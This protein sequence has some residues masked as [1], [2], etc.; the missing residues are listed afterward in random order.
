VTVSRSGR[1][2][3]AVRQFGTPS[4]TFLVDRMIELERLGWEAWVA[5]ESVIDNGY[6]DFP[7]DERLLVGRR[8]ERL[9]ARLRAGL[10]LRA[11]PPPAWWVERAIEAVRPKVVHAHFGWNGLTALP[12]AR[13]RQVPLVVGLHGYDVTVYPRYGFSPPENLEA[14]GGGGE[15][16]YEELFDEASVIVTSRYLERRLRDLGYGQPVEVIPSGIRLDRFPFRGP[17]PDPV[18]CRLLFVGRL[19]PYKGLDVLVRALA[20]LRPA[21]DPLHLDVVGDGPVR[22]PAERLAEQLGVADL[23]RF[24]GALPQSGVRR[25]FEQSDVLVAPSRTTPAGQAEALGNAIKEALAVGLQVVASR[26]GGIPE[27]TPPEHRP[28]LISEGDHEALAARIEE[29]WGD[30]GRW[31]TRAELG[32]R[33]VQETFDWRILAPRIASVYESSV[34]PDRGR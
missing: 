25:A 3:H 24:H 10:R 12:A 9:V 1:V 27:V 2:L 21:V 5:A 34:G 20:A 19:V 4:E 33:W 28:E 26:N 15:R 31:R 8:R 13:D 18:D 7:P 11:G 32:R 22:Q 29:L 14:A 6:F 23:V 16:V 30:R 17:R